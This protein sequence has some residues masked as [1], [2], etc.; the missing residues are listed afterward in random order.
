MCSVCGS[1]TL[2]IHNSRHGFQSKVQRSVQHG[3]FSCAKLPEIHYAVWIYNFGS[4][5]SFEREAAF[6]SLQEAL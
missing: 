4:S 1:C 3:K 6:Q 2:T 5:G